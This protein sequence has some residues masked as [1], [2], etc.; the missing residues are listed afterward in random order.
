M[1]EFKNVLIEQILEFLGLRSKMY[2]LTV[3][4]ETKSKNICKGIKKEV[5]KNEI[6]IEDY[7]NTLYTHESKYVYQNSIRSYEHELYSET[8]HKKALSCNDDKIYICDNN[9][10]TYSF[11]NYK[12]I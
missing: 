2:S 1:S 8:Q 12:I 4:G 9:I 11:G 5:V 7:V 3:D 10:N 6:K